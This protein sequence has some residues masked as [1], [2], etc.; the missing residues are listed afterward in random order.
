MFRKMDVAM[1]VF[2]INFLKFLPSKNTLSFPWVDQK[3]RA[4]DILRKKKAKFCGIFRGNF[5][6]KSADFVGFS[7]GKEVEIRK[8]IGRFSG[9]FAGEKSKFT[10]KLANF[11]GN[12]GGKLCRETINKKQ[13]ITLDFFWQ[14]SLKSINFT[15]I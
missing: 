1:S 12:F 7:R 11:T 5:V 4:S 8:K 9:I 10:E 15:S 3:V 6:E 2:K 13:P 14:I